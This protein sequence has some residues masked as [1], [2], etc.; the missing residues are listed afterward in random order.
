MT[1]IDLIGYAAAFGTSFSFVPQV[2]KI[3]RTGNTEGISLLMYSI[4]VV[5]IACW[6]TFGLMLGSWPIIAANA[7]TLV[8]SGTVLILKIVSRR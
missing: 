5:G 3:I 1:S 6:L 8:L 2:Y 4:Y 7:L